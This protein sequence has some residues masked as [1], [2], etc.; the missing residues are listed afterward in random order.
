MLADLLFR[1][2]ALLRRNGLEAELDEEMRFHFDR[3]VE[4][5]MRS[6]LTRQEAARRA[7]LTF[8][9]IEQIKDECREARGV[10]FVETLQRDVLYSLRMLGKN[11]RF[12]VI[13]VL[14]I[15]LGIGANTAIFS[16][17]DAVLL[18]PLP[19]QDPAS[20][21]LVWETKEPD[22]DQHNTVSPPDFLDWQRQS[23][24]F[25]GLVS[26]ADERDNL[27][28]SG[29][30]EQVVVQLVSGN[31]FS[32][33]GVNPVVGRGF[34][35]EDGK[36][37]KD[38]VVVISYG[39]WQERFAGS[40]AIIGRTIELNGHPQ[41]IVGVAP[42]DFTSFIKHGSLTGGKPRLWA[43]FVFP[44]AFHDRQAVGRF[45]TVLGRLKPHVGL[46]R[47]RSEMAA[48]AAR[49]AKEHPEE[50]G[51]WNVNL[52]PLRE[53][54]SGDLR[55]A[56]L[57]LSGA[58]ALVLLIACAN[59]AGLLLARAASRERELAIRTA[60]GASRGRIARQLLTESVLLALIGGALGVA[61]A[62]AGTN[63]LL[64]ASPE[65]LLDL[66]SV[67]V[68]AR[69]LVFA[70]AITL[71]AGMLFGF[72]PSYLSARTRI[73]DTL[74][75]G[76]G[77]S[78]GGGG[79]VGRL[80][81]LG[82]RST[83]VV[84][85]MGLALVLLAGSGL[86]LRSFVRLMGVDM[87]FDPTRVLSFTVALPAS[88]YA[89]DPAHAAFFAQLLSRLG[90]LPGVRS[91]SM[92]SCPPL[93]GLGSSTAVHILGQPVRA[94][95]DLP[96]AAVRVVGPDY[97]RTLGITLRSGRT[98]SAREMN[99]ARHVVIVN[100]VFAERYLR[101]ANALGRR[102]VIFMKS[103]TESDI[104]PSEIIGIVGS[105]REIGLDAAPEPT[106]YWPYPELVMSRMTILVRATTDPLALIAAARREVR[107]MDAQLPVASVSTMERIV[108]DSLARSRFTM[109][110]L[111]LFGGAALVL[112]T[113][114]V[115]GVIAY[116]VAQRTH[117]LGIRLAIGA[118]RRDLLR[119]MLAQGTR[120]TLLGV[121][122]GIAGA[123]ALTRLLARFLFGISATD[124]VSLAGAAILLAVVALGACWIPSRRAM[125]ADPMAALRHD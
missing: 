16:V 104:E 11:P 72:L 36:P 20:L 53:E 67:A 106:V 12:A 51:H 32:L 112:A 76:G 54:I 98:F 9:G 58:V 23:T 93:S 13:A 102:A 18:R 3:L 44:P 63:A 28:G 70:A 85:Q 57:I 77:R 107:Q 103:F 69:V 109:L 2:R 33:L 94:L 59:V 65:N 92:N 39:L 61:A 21:V 118:Q 125:R 120:L 48:V 15:A 50:N 1:L 22:F 121:G 43:P 75:A 80:G 89:S 88:R 30:P 25:A 117:E 41:I 17:I 45:L 100:Q 96:Q 6:G 111:G 90:R 66:R 73:A 60:I 114:G 52:V 40:P 42:G 35:A 14:T 38:K 7:R 10:S 79:R 110:L 83:F 86:L 97:F 87:G 29:E 71:L 101:G 84:A 26:I 47:A 122:L 78:A 119:L 113:V 46:A 49:I 31:F 64:A 24:A 105:V 68:D 37:G 82:G 56:L 62:F 81:R 95:N 99:E 115:Y 55:P 123:L 116:S 124:P 5:N 74:K 91:A 27:T 8:G 4:K 34:T 108:A 19:Y